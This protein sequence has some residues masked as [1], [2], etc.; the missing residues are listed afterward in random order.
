MEDLGHDNSGV[1][2]DGRPEEPGAA[3]SW[4]M[5]GPFLNMPWRKQKQV[6]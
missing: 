6:L 2:A 5:H 3:R 4:E 1:C